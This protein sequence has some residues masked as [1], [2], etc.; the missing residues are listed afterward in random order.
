MKFEI[1]YYCH[2]VTVII[3]VI[4]IIIIIVTIIL[5][6]RSLYADCVHCEVGSEFEKLVKVH[7]VF[8]M[9]T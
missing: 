1:R 7:T 4:I 2:F 8:S 5:K 6:G 3:I 9:Q